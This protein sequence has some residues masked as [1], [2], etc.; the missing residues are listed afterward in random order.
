M[1]RPGKKRQYIE[2]T[3]QQPEGRWKTVGQDGLSQGK[4]SCKLKTHLSSHV[5]QTPFSISIFLLLP[6][7]ESKYYFGNKFVLCSKS[8]NKMKHCISIL[9]MFLRGLEFILLSIFT[10]ILLSYSIVF[11]MCLIKPLFSTSN[12]SEDVN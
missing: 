1:K 3:R 6:C 10:Y 2:H 11:C 9:S 7:L 8:N 12:F 4:N 5:P